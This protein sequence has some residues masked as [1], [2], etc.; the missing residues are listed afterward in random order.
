MANESSAIVQR[1][2]NYCNVLRDDG[3]SYGDYVEQ[4]TYLLFLKMADEQ[5]KIL[6]KQTNIPKGLDWS[7]LTGKDGGI[8]KRCGE[9][10]W[11]IDNNWMIMPCYHPSALLRNPNWKEPAWRALQKV[12]KEL[13]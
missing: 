5:E 3:V 4:L 12:A 6:K 1:L 11:E 13:L 8:V 10:E 9:W 2:W 7:S